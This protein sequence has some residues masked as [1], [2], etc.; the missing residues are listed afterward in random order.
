VLG[1][2]YKAFSQMGN[3]RPALWTKETAKEG[4]WSQTV[5]AFAL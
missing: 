5:E 4:E 1:H 3:E 2:R